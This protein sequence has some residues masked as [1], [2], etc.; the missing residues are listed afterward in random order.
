MKLNLYAIYDGVAQE[1][2]PPFLS[3]N[4]SLA[5]RM[6]EVSM[7]K[8][9]YRADFRLYLIGY[10][11]TSSMVVSPIPLPSLVESEVPDVTSQ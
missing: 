1:S 7:D 11:D 2:S 9:R 5:L 3:K 8:E 10:Y 6:Y 4:H